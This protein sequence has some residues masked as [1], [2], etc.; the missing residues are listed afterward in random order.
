MLRRLF[1]VASVSVAT[2][3]LAACQDTPTSVSTN[4]K[5]GA[6]LNGSGVPAKVTVFYLT[7]P[8]KFNSAD[9]FSLTGSAQATLGADLVATDSVLLTPGGTKS[10]SR[11]FDGAQPAYM[12]VVAGFRALGTAQWRAVT[13]LKS[14]GA[15]KVTV[16]VGSASINVSK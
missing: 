16:S 11:T 8:T 14:G 1:L 10:L 12:G 5:G 6:S 15:N 2:F 4:I 13:G 9:F 3:A 7:D